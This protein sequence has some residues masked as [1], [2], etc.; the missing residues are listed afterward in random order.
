R[1]GY[2]VDNEW[3][4]YL[5]KV[6]EQCQLHGKAPGRFK[7]TLKD[8]HEF[9]YSIIVD[10]F[11]LEDGPVLHVVDSATAFNAGKFLREVSARTTWEALRICW[12][13]AYQGP[14]EYIVER[15]HGPVRRAYD[16]IKAEFQA[17]GGKINKEL[18][19]QM[20]F[21]AINDTAGPDGL[22]PTLLTFGAYP[23]MTEM[24][25]P[26][27]VVQRARAIQLAMKELRALNAKRMMYEFGENMK[28]RT[29]VE[30]GL[31]HIPYC[32]FK[33]KPVLST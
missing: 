32:R 7:F 23:R 33:A 27:T 3:I 22:V 11:Y 24:D 12:I 6:C 20:A 14:P 19:L 31:D 25:P 21:K 8:D 4:K 16:I 18:I 28:V 13:D 1:A 15:Y 30:A 2:D 26:P 9:N 5:T 10:I 29:D 17:S